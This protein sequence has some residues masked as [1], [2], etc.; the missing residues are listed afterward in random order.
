M[1]GYFLW[2][3]RTCLI[4]YWYIIYKNDG[5]INICSCN[6]RRLPYSG[7]LIISNSRI[8][9]MAQLLSYL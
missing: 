7:Y 6:V 1:F 3:S 9:S 5:K 8:F 4:R 2:L